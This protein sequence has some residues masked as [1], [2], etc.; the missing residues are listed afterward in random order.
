MLKLLPCP[1]SGR[2][3][4]KERDCELHYTLAPAMANDVR[5]MIASTVDIDWSIVDLSAEGRVRRG[6]GHVRAAYPLAI[7]DVIIAVV[8][9]MHVKR[10]VLGQI[11]GDHQQSTEMRTASPDW[12]HAHGF[13]PLGEGNFEVHLDAHWLDLAWR[14]ELNA[15][16]R[17]AGQ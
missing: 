14:K 4:C 7:R 3:A 12:L 16:R 2:Q 17:E 8:D 6:M 15:W 9:T 1:I 5:A 13:L 11:Y 10:S